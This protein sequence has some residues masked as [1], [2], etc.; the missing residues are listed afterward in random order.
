MRAKLVAVAAVAAVAAGAMP[1]QAALKAPPKKPP[2]RIQVTAKE[3][4]YGLSGRRFKPG[5][6]IVEL[7]NFGEDF[8]DL[9]LQRVG[10]KKV[11]RIPAVEPGKFDDLELTLR[12]GTYRLWCSI[13]N[14]AS[15]GM[16]AKIVVRK[17]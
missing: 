12:P 14:H 1:L 2:T 11:F 7:V 16:K 3:F 10:D 17:Q 15:L 8:H 4:W 13:A 6:A 5:P 9:R